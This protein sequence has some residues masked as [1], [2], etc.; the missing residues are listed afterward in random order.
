VLAAGTVLGAY[1]LE[2]LVAHGGMGSIYRAR[3]ERLGRV[4]ALKVL[5]PGLAA[6]PAFRR[7]FLEE[8]RIAAGLD[9][10]HVI[11]IY[12]AGEAEGLLF[13]AMRYVEGADLGTVLARERRLAPARA[14]GLLRGIADAL[15][16]AHA[17]GL[18]HRDVK[19]ENILV[20][21]G[22]G[23]EH[24]Y[25]ADFGLSRERGGDRGLTQSGQFAGSIDY[26]APEQIRGEPVEAPIDVY[27][28]ACVAFT[29]LTGT[30]PFASPSEIATLFGHLN[31]PPPALAEHDGSLARFDPA[32][33]RGLAKRPIDRPATA[34]ALIEALADGLPGGP[35]Q[36]DAAVPGVPA[37]PGLPPNATSFVGRHREVADIAARLAEN[38]LVTLTGPGGIGKSR[39]AA[40][41]A[42]SVAPAFPG[43]VHFLELAPVADVE[44]VPSAL[45]A[46]LGVGGESADIDAALARALAGPRRLLVL[47][48]IEHLVAAGEF[49]SRLLTTCPTLTVLATGRRG[50]HLAGERELPVEPLATPDPDAPLAE[51][52][53]SPPVRLFLDRARALRPELELTPDEIRDVAAICARLDGLPLAIELAAARSRVLPPTAILRRLDS[54]LGGLGSG[55]VDAPARHRALRA[56]IAWSEALLTDDERR[57][58]RDVSVFVGGWTLEAAE[59]VF[60]A[61]GAAGPGA[62]DGAVDALGLLEA[63]ADQSLIRSTAATGGEPRFAVLETIREYAREQLETDGRTAIVAAA[64][65]EHVTAFAELADRGLRGSDQEIWF[66]RLIVEVPNVEAALRWSIEA[67]PDLC[68]RLAVAMW[69]FWDLRGDF[70]EGRAWLER[71]LAACPDVGAA[72]RA[73]ALNGIG[74]L[75]EGLG[76]GERSRAA[77]LEAID[78]RRALGDEFGTGIVLNNLGIIERDLGHADAAEAAWLEALA[79]FEAAGKPERVA[80]VVGNLGILARDRGDF[81]EAQRLYEAGLEVDRARNDLRSV[82]ADLNNLGLVALHLSELVKSGRLFHE[83][84]LLKRSFGDRSGIAEVIEGLAGIAGRRGDGLRAA[85]LYGSAEAI[86]TAIGAPHTETEVAPYRAYVTEARALLDPVSFDAAWADGRTLDFASAVAEAVAWSEE[87]LREP[88]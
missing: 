21:V 2:E 52:L 64:H 74:N 66:N 43:G 32:I 3:D 85:R 39:L 33:R 59:H 47:D 62:G 48:N 1:R 79:I 86:R 73:T 83:S 8:S 55:P 28:L 17:R 46:L 14:I 44:L 9:H 70:R 24:A 76:D 38:R 50:F 18:V 4:V 87:V 45:A 80:T 10:P 58:F 82:S 6:D 60:A 5:A 15:D 35:D 61:D 29:C 20:T 11:P 19:P 67:D 68:L 53:E 51:V 36:T 54:R 7:R 49:V 56:T 26:A 42:V 72:L 84:L 27:S 81:A 41:A 40:R 78:L 16:A 69:W 34:A 31:E 77:F 23:P 63:L 12:E 25:L 37:I 13:I 71:A 75:A 22:G 65:A 30:P 57:A 88:E